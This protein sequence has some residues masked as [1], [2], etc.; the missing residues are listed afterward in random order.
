MRTGVS[1]GPLGQCGQE[2]RPE[3]RPGLKIQRLVDDRLILVT[4]DPDVDVRDNYVFVHWGEAFRAQHALKFPALHNPGLTLD[5]GALGVNHI[6][7][8]KASG[9]FPERIVQPH[10]NAGLLHQVANAP[11]FS[12]PV[13]LFYQEEFSSPKTMELTLTH[14]KERL[15]AHVPRPL[16]SDSGWRRAAVALVMRESNRG[17]EVLMVLRA[18]RPGDP[19]AGHMGFPGGRVEAGDADDERA[20]VRETWEEIGVRLDGCAQRI[21]TLS[22]IQ[23]RSRSGLLPLKIQPFVYEVLSPIHPQPSAEVVESVWM[24]LRFFRDRRNRMVMRHPANPELELPCYILTNRTVWGL[25]L[26]MLDELVFRVVP[27]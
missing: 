8:Q 19:W 6:I 7:H 20:A 1:A 14:L 9:Y 12:Y 4:A 10:I 27:E 3:H 13:F 23:A 26:A 16:D 2:C 24:P 25:S 22:E 5:L 21:G 17:P 15:A 18:N 11:V